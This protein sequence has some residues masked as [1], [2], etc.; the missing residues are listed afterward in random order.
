MLNS[1]FRLNNK[2]TIINIEGILRRLIKEAN[3]FARNGSI[4]EPSASVPRSAVEEL[5]ITRL[6]EQCILHAT[7]PSI[8]LL[9]SLKLTIQS[10]FQHFAWNPS[11]PG[12]DRISPVHL[13]V[14]LFPIPPRPP[15]ER[16]TEWTAPRTLL[17]LVFCNSGRN[18]GQNPYRPLVMS[19]YL[20]LLFA[21][22]AP[23]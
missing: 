20:Y 21:V 9:C 13:I 14:D 7:L 19:I 11:C 17:S 15:E 5:C 18:R 3:M 8:N 16:T 22:A 23:F 1:L 2:R 4:K 12:V 6:I 10:G